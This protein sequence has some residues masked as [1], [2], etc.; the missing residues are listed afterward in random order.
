MLIFSSFHIF[1]NPAY[2][3]SFEENEIE[4]Y[5]FIQNEIP[6]GSILLSDFYSNKYFFYPHFS[7][8]DE[9]NVPYFE[10]SYLK[11][12]IDLSDSAGYFIFPKTGS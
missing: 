3:Q 9:L 6:Y 12:L 10:S 1:D 11:K 8:T 5:N 2:I 7:D 4:G